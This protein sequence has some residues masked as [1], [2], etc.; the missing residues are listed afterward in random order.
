[1]PLMPMPTACLV[2]FAEDRRRFAATPTTPAAA[3]R[4]HAAEAKPELAPPSTCGSEVEA[5]RAGEGRAAGAA[6]TL[7]K[8]D[9]ESHS[10]ISPRC[11]EPW[12]TRTHARTRSQTDID[13]KNCLSENCL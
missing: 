5:R 3:T 8:Q 13:T 12:C 9:A 4:E 7:T 1:M 11:T 2:T 6:G 10:A